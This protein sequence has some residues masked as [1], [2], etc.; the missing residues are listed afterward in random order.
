[1]REY[2]YIVTILLY[3]LLNSSYLFSLTRN[4]LVWNTKAY[5]SVT[6]GKGKVF[7]LQARFWP[8][9]WV[10]VIALLF[11]DHGS[12]RGWVVSSTPRP[13]FTSGKAR[14]PIV[15]EAEWATGPVRKGG[16]S[17]PTGIWS[18]DRPAR[19]QSLYQLS[20]PAHSVTEGCH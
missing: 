13:Y 4:F 12:R 7:P 16:K 8:R 15:Q 2:E 20:Y 14:V 3:F 11:H 6:E 5:F 18:A 19:S 1:M 17:R 9:G 10:E